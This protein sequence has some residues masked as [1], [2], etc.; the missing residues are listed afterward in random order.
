[1]N[2][3]DASVIIPTYNRLDGLKL[4]LDSLISQKCTHK[5]EVIV[6]DDGS[7]KDTKSLVNMY[8]GK[9]NIKYIFQED[10]G[11]RVAAA[12]NLGIKLSVGKYCIFLDTGIIAH[13]ELVETYINEHDKGKNLALIGYVFGFDDK[14]ITS[15]DESKIR[16]YVKENILETAFCKVEEARLYDAREE[17]YCVLG[18][19]LTKWP[20]PFIIFWSGNMSVSRSL[21]LE[22][23]MFDE[24][25]NSWGGEDTELGLSLQKYG[26]KF[27]L[28]KE[29]KAIHYPHKK[30]ESSYWKTNEDEAI[31]QLI[32]KKLY[33]YN[34]H[35]I[36]EMERWLV[37]YNMLNL[38]LSLLE[39]ES[40]SKIFLA[41][42]NYP[43][44]IWSKIK[45]AEV[46]E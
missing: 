30:E 40:N 44:T 31:S 45:R 8:L 42:T 12:R 21:L 38:N 3:I 1:M 2:G 5:F 6:V 28:C 16:K 43:N 4:T 46:N 7:T 22:V 23:G 32:I 36:K 39:E 9:L 19:D 18:D 25:F 26:A 10:K 34:K 33:M 29:A 20:A 24:Y 14:K 35:P 11:F 13:P 37:V 17:L 15:N 27:I 41:D